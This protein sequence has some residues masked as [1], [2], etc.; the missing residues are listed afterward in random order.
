MIKVG[1][2]GASG[3]MGQQAGRAVESVDDLAL[4][5]AVGR[6]DPLEPLDRCDV[7]IDFTTPETVLR[8]I[9]YCVDRDIHMVVGTSGFTEERLA[10]VRERLAAHPDVGVLVVPSFS[11]GAVVMMRAARAAAG[12]FESV[13]IIEMHHPDKLDAPSGTAMHTAR[14]VAEAR[15]EAGRGDV[16]DATEHDPLG[17]RGGRVEGIPLHS[18]RVRGLV[19]HQEVLFGNQGETLT[20]RHDMVDRNA[21]MPGLLA[22]V[23]AIRAMPGLT[24]GLE[25]VLGLE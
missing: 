12:L 19:A 14:Q 1:V 2:I 10:T 21:A 8:H 24:V 9:D 17:S 20:L 25:H 22:A 18:V 23:R 6:G 16:P 3:K 11:I 13:E 4:V 15:R 5:A 7:A